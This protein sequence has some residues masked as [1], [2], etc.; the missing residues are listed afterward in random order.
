[1]LQTD[2]AA[3]FFVFFK[4]AK[5]VVALQRE[6]GKCVEGKEDERYGRVALFLVMVVAVLV[7]WTCSIG[8][9]VQYKAF[10]RDYYCKEI[11]CK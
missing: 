8:K 6:N 10:T 3:C 7:P 11:S 9:G 1:M 2:G 5:R 4:L